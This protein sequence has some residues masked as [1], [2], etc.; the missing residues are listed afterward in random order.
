M[1]EIRGKAKG[2]E[3]TA[4]QQQLNIAYRTRIKLFFRPSGLSGDSNSA[5]EDLHWSYVNNHK[6][7]VNNPSGFYVSITGV[8][9][10]NGTVYSSVK[11]QMLA[12]GGTQS[13]ELNNTG[14][15]G[16][17]SF[18]AINDYGATIEYSAKG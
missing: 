6:V 17:L 14:A 15:S 16:K 8:H 13:Y 4:N 9:Y 2:T 18:T 11:G 10:K 7:S 12:P 1:L 5:A 3:D